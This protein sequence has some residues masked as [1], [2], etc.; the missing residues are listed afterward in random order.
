MLSPYRVL[1]FTDHRGEFAG[2]VLSDLGADVI[3][4]EPPGGSLARFRGPRQEGA[5]EAEASLQFAAFNRGKRSIVLD[6]HRE[7]ARACLLELVAG[8]DFVLES[9]PAGP[10]AEASLGFDELRE[11]SPRIV[12]VE[13]TPDPKSGSAGMPRPTSDALFCL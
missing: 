12:H 13:T 11:A 8:A 4:V 9:A 3:R 5:P 10:L 6:L 1:D 7:E 2:M